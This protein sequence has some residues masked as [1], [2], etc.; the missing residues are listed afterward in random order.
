MR[1]W[2]SGDSARVA[3]N[4][5]TVVDGLRLADSQQFSFR[6][7]SPMVSELRSR[8]IVCIACG[9]WLCKSC[10]QCPAPITTYRTGCFSDRA[11]LFGFGWNV[12]ISKAAVNAV[13]DACELHTFAVR[14]SHPRPKRRTAS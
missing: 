9:V 7:A 14:F 4:D 13:S 10:G 12:V 11:A 1:V 5:V 3:C 6:Y 8:S 2:M